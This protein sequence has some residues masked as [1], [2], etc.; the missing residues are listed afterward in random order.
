MSCLQRL[1]RRPHTAVHCGSAA[2]Y[3]ERHQNEIRD[4]LR[5]NVEARLHAELLS[6]VADPRTLRIAAE[7]IA[8]DGGSASGGDGVRPHDLDHR[9]WTALI[10]VLSRL[11]ATGGYTPGPERRSP[12]PKASGGFRVLSIPTVADRVVQRAILEIVNPMIDPTFSATT[13]GGR[14][15]RSTWDALIEADRFFRSANTFFVVADVRKAFD[16]VPH[17]EL[18]T[19]LVSRLGN[20]SLVDLVLRILQNGRTIGIGQGGPLSPLLLNMY[21][22]EVLDRPWRQQHPDLPLIRWLDDLL[23]ACPTRTAADSALD[24]L[25]ACMVAAKMP[26]KTDPAPGVIDLIRGK[27]AEWL[28]YRIMGGPDGLEAQIPDSAWVDLRLDLLEAHRT[29]HPVATARQVGRGWMAYYGPC[30]QRDCNDTATRVVAILE[31]HGFGEADTI[32][33]LAKLR[34]ESYARFV[35]RRDQR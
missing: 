1:R 25:S 4:A 18:V 29:D 14:T 32:E 9:D 21:L 11:I 12:I 5:N 3:L 2:Q 19:I 20:T 17:C 34:N 31:E 22:D 6:R 35:R 26:L 8:N 23:V 33:A 16:V 24:D 28:G 30:H 7:H 10:G 13:L 27:S 15:E